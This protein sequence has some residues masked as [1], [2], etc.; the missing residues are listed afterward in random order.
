MFC[1]GLG[2][3]WLSSVMSAP[4]RVWAAQLPNH[5]S[6]PAWA[7]SKTFHRRTNFF[8]ALCVCASVCYRQLANIAVLC[9]ANARLPGL[10]LSAAQTIWINLFF[11]V[12]HTGTTVAAC[13][14]AAS[15]R[16]WVYAAEQLHFFTSAITVFQEILSWQSFK[17]TNNVLK[18]NP[19][20]SRREIL[21]WLRREILF[22]LLTALVGGAAHCGWLWILWCPDRLRD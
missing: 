20:V 2:P 13:R 8:S 18:R 4:S 10:P 15:S 12:S 14:W 9:Y 11:Y 3:T 7:A 1:N 17:Y 19:L 21:F 6:G 5:S 22:W 16:S